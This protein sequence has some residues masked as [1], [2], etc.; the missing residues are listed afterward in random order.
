MRPPPQP[1][2]HLCKPLGFYEVVERERREHRPVSVDIG[3]YQ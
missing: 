1:L 3:F 2:R